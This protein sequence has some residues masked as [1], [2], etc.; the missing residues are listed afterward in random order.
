MENS[1]EGWKLRGS[2]PG[3]GEIGSSSPNVQTGSG[4]HAAHF[5]KCT[6]DKA[7]GS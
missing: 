1:L 3:S 6:G 7:A 4:A 5:S 2:N